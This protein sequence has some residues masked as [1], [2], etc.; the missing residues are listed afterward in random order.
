MSSVVLLG[1]ESDA[2]SERPVARV[3]EVYQVQLQVA[4]LTSDVEH[5]RVDVADIKVDLRRL[6]TKIDSV[7]QRLD[8]KIDAVNARLSS[9]EKEVMGKFGENKVWMLSLHM[10]QAAGL[11]LIIAKA[12]KW[13]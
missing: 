7:E 8:N 10:A 13:L 12:F 2:R 4:K 6:D 3:D 9:F 5:I 1:S 11:L